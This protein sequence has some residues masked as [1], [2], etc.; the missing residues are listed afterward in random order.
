MALPDRQ[1]NNQTIAFLCGANR[2]G[3]RLTQRITL[4]GEHFSA[5]EP[6]GGSEEL[7]APFVILLELIAS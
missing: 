3:G 2:E 6:P 1:C 4:G 7:E 5:A